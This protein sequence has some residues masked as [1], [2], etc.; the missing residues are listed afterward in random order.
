MKIRVIG[1][2]HGDYGAYQ[3]II[4]GCES[5]IQVGD[6]GIGFINDGFERTESHR[7]IRGNHDDPGK[8]KD[9]KHWIP[10]GTSHAG[11]FCVGGGFSID[12]AWRIEGKSWWPD[13]ELS[14]KEMYKILDDYEKI[15]PDYVIS[16]EGPG[17]V[18]ERMFHDKTLMRPFS[19]TSQML[20]AMFFIHQPKVWF[21]GHWHESRHYILNQTDFICLG[22]NAYTDV[23]I[24]TGH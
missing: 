1:D 4:D 14:Q 10:D 22:I 13:E 21:F 20:D 7:F 12:R 19:R 9:N 11:F 17:D 6:F 8:C 5:S 15:K 18:I 16:H 23:N 2:I 24:D 3:Q